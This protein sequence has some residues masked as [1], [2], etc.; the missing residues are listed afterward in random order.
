[1]DQIISGN[2]EEMDLSLVSSRC[3]PCFAPETDFGAAEATNCRY[4]GVFPGINRMYLRRDIPV[5]HN[6]AGFIDN[7]ALQEIDAKIEG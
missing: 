7:Q 2:V 4:R 3:W 1:V 5:S 6:V